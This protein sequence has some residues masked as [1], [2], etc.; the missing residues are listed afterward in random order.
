MLNPRRILIAATAVI[1]LS[2][3]ASQ[4]AVFSWINYLKFRTEFALPG[5]ELPRG[6]YAFEVVNPGTDADV[7]RVSSMDGR[8]VFFTGFTR[9]VPRPAALPKAQ[10]VIFGEAP[11][12]SAQPVRA[13]FP[14]DASMGHQFLY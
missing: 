8:Q 1:A 9:R 2:V 7:V 13:W 6:V 12:G 4:A 14:I 5:V 3:A 10:M 11:S